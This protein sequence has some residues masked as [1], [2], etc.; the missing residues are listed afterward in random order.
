MNL[1]PDQ[2]A[3]LSPEERRALLS[4]LLLARA[5]QTR[6]LPASHN[7]RALW[8]LHQLAPDSAAYNESFAWRVR[9]GADPAVLR[10]AVQDLIDRH[11]ML[12]TTFARQ[13]S[14]EVVQTVHGFRDVSC[15]LRDAAGWAEDRL[16]S[17]LT[18][19]ARRPFDLE[20]GPLLRMALFRRSEAECVLQ[21]TVHHIAL[22]LWSMMLLMAELQQLAAARIAGVQAGLPPARDGY[23]EFVRWQAAMTA[24]PEGERHWQFWREKLAGPPPALTLPADR[25][26]P[27]VQSYRGRAHPFQLSPDLTRRLRDLS[28]AE[29]VTLYTTLLAAFQVLLGRY[30]GQDEFLVGTMASG[31]TRP[32]FET[33]V[34]LFVNQVA[35]RADLR[36]NPPFRALL[37]RT[38]QTVLEAL[39]HQDYPFPLLVERLQLPRDP[40]RSPLNDVSFALQQ[41]RAA[42]ATRQGPNRF[43]MLDEADPAGAVAGVTLG[44]SLIELIPLDPDVAKSDLDLEMV[45]TGDVLSGWFRYS[46]DLFDAGTIARMAGHFGRLLAGIAEGP[47]RRLA[48]LPML[49][50]GERR[51]LLA[52]GSG[53]A[54]AARPGDGCA[55]QLF[56]AQARRT[57]AAEAVVAGE[58]RVT[59]ADLDARANRLARRLRALG[60]APESRV[61]LVLENTVHRLVGVLG[62]LKAG[63]AY[64]PLDPASPRARLESMLADAA[65]AVVVTEAHLR[66]QLPDT[67]AVLD[68]DAEADALA[69]LPEHDLPPWAGPANLAY[70][71]FTSGSTGRPKGVMVPHKNLVNAYRGWEAAY[72]LREDTSSHLQMAGF[73]F[74]VF[75]VDWVRALGSG[76]KLVACP[77]D[78]LLSPADLYD[79]MARERVDCA[80]FVPA[81]AENL[82]RHLT[83][84]GLSLGFMRLLAVG[85]DALHAGTFE[86]LRRLA[87]GARLV[88]SYGLTEATIDSTFFEG[89]LADRAP[90]QPVPIG[91]PFPGT[92]VYLLDRHLHPAPV[93]VP[94]ELYIGGSGVARGY[95]GRPGLTAERFVPDPFGGEPGGRLYRTGDVARWLPDGN[96]ELVGRSDHQVKVRGVRVELGEVESALLGHPA[97]RQAVAA[98]R[99]DAPG[100]PGVVAYVTVAGGD[101]P[102][103][104]AALRAH[105][106]PRLPGAMLP[107][108]FVILDRFP[109][110][111]NGKVDRRALPAPDNRATGRGEPVAPRNAVEEVLLGIWSEAL[112]RDGLG[113]DDNFFESGGHSLLA[114]QL[115][116]RVREAFQAELPLARVFERPTVA[117]VASALLEA[118]GQRERVE[119]TAELLLQ[120]AGLS[121]DDLDEMLAEPAEGRG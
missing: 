39:A 104:P 78:I 6:T 14:G 46:T 21:T 57:P 7:Q 117:G 99:E 96:L 93:G 30:T 44:G 47:G 1:S 43:A 103:T 26:R 121:D 95:L 9:S 76:A 81:V 94:G 112:G 68:L 40:S 25:P 4:R 91:R 88:D 50:E 19:E 119:K 20:H 52:G 105:L 111:P 110:T 89:G 80:E 53:P 84:R 18:E 55:H 58:Q 61:A 92:R 102:L 41:P 33:A 109:L 114:T 67:A 16:K 115:V 36:G 66:P 54:A 2:L 72:R 11:S 90:G 77:R 5:S 12:R 10:A 85:S 24:G 48:E 69:R 98:L 101:E 113:V 79:L 22:D 65:A 64:V 118:P 28:R 13:D 38:R 106:V 49:T 71:V 107:A 32:E 108:A 70:V 15:E 17:A 73:A 3:R 51:E 86:R 42:E 31:R 60:V 27:A 74:D 75:T 59:Y 63:G 35:L 29:G 116:S 37:G 56:E 87:G 100:G 120:M 34:G 8:F 23:E 82:M 62:T 97:V 83:E 45:E